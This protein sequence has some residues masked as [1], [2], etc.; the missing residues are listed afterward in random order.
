MLWLRRNLFL[1]ISGLIA[2]GLLGGGSWYLWTSKQRNNQVDTKRQ[3][4]EAIHNDTKSHFPSPTNI[5]LG[6]KELQRVKEFT[7]KMKVYFA[8][9]AAPNVAGP[10]FRSMLDITVSELRKRA[11][12]QGIGLPGRDYAFSFEAQRKKLQ[13]GQGTFP[14]MPQQVVEI[15]ALCNL[16]FDSQIN[17]LAGLR[18]T[19]VSE[20]D[21]ANKGSPDYNE[22]PIQTNTATKCV[23]TPYVVEF[24]CF[25]DGL[26]AVTRRLQ[27]STN[28]FTLKSVMVEPSS[29][30][31]A[32]DSTTPG[33]P[34]P[35]TLPPPTGAAPG[36]VPPVP[37]VPPAPIPQ[38][39][40]P[41]PPG[42]PAPGAVVPQRSV[43]AKPPPPD[44][45]GKTIL[46]ERLLK[47]TMMVEV[48]KCPQQ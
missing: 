11:E 41:P 32:V 1:T 13:F 19:R 48:I 3:A 16:L 29:A 14:A 12:G 9:I 46:D 15:Y 10:E 18:R 45:F 28:G 17:K 20:D 43:Y 47:V 36:A 39:G 38:P 37:G 2:L 22:L 23:I 6:K 25:S 7:Q 34:A 5:D 35:G 26:S 42:I 33:A 40:V 44:P 8:P 30:T 4:L 27:E 24:N 21:E 31:V